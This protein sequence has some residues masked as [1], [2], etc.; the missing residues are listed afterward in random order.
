MDSRDL[1]LKKLRRAAP[2]YAGQPLPVQH[3][4]VTPFVDTD[5]AVLRARFMAE[6]EKLRCQVHRVADEEAALVQVLTLLGEDKTFVSW[7]AEHLPIPHLLSALA[8]R[9][10]QRLPDDSSQA[11]VGITGAEALL[12]STGS[13]V[14][15][16]GLGR[17]RTV[18]L[19]PAVHVVLARQEQIIPD[20]ETYLARIRAQ[21]L[22][23][24]RSAANV[25]VITGASRTAD[26][27]MELVL[28]AH[29]PAALHI[30]LLD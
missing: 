29:G 28:G 9:G 10:L 2:P 19:L 23:D 4:R 1:I 15:R 24:F 3:P 11:R 27:A 26:I 7:D 18:S 22:A 8:E 16:S 5:P 12:A 17:A 21:G 30:I 6:V 25:L 13:V 14:L 20:L